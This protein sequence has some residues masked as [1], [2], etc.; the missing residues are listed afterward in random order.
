IT[1]VN[2]KVGKTGLAL[3]ASAALVAASIGSSSAAS[4][5]T[6]GGVKGGDMSL[7]TAD[8]ANLN[9]TLNGLDLAVAGDLGQN[10]VKDARG[11]GAGWNLTISGTAFTSTTGKTLPENALA[12]TG[13]TATKVAGRDPQNQISYASGIV[14]PL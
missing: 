7:V 9:T 12:I 1:F 11:T 14:V 5:P 10:T 3:V 2:T 4:I 13:V 6:Q 8:K